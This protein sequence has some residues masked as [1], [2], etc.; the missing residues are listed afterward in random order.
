MLCYITLFCEKRSFS[1]VKRTS[2]K[3]TKKIIYKKK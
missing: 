3:D 2:K 1:Y